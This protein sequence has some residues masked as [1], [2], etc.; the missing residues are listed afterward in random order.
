MSSFIQKAVE[1]DCFFHRWLSVI[2]GVVG[3][4]ILAGAATQLNDP[5]NMTGKTIGKLSNV[6]TTSTVNNKGEVNY[7]VNMNMTYTFKGDTVMKQLHSSNN[8]Y[9]NGQEVS[10]LYN[11][12]TGDAVIESEY[13][14]PAATARLIMMTACSCILCCFLTFIITTTDWGCKLL[15]FSDIVRLGTIFF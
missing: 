9:M 11:P 6:T 5:S 10:I 2:L 1:V 13:M 3:A 8:K 15:T 7:S 12:S 4:V 14:S